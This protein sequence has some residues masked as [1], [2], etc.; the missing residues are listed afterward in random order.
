MYEHQKSKNTNLL[1]HQKHRCRMISPHAQTQ[2]THHSHKPIIHQQL[3]EPSLS[4]IASSIHPCFSAPPA[5]ATSITSFNASAT[6]FNPSQYSVPINNKKRTKAKI[7]S[8]E[9]TK[10]DFL[11]LEL[12]SAKTRIVQ[13]E[14][15]IDDR[16]ISIKTTQF[17]F[18]LNSK[19]RKLQALPQHLDHS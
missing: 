4:T 8:P 18:F 2:H 17:S 7:M 14:S 16:D 10:V 1:T 9:K 11:N 13:L 3:L 12:D 5:L 6:P 19:K 15:D